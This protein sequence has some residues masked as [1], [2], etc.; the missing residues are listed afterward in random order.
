MHI[1]NNSIYILYV[2][3][4]HYHRI[5]Y[6]CMVQEFKAMLILIFWE[7]VKC[8]FAKCVVPVKLN[9]LQA[10]ID[11]LLCKSYIRTL[12]INFYR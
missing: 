8:I 3:L 10:S 6:I 2:C 12:T 9:K 7:A 5:Y 1:S 4:V 11:V